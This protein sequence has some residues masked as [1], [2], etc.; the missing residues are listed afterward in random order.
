MSTKN[1]TN[2]RCLCVYYGWKRHLHIAKVPVQ[3]VGILISWP[4]YQ[5]HTSTPHLSFLLLSVLPLLNLPPIQSYPT[6]PLNTPPTLYKRCFHNLLEEKRGLSLNFQSNFRSQ[7]RETTHQAETATVFLRCW[8]FCTLFKPKCL[9]YGNF[10][11]LLG[12]QWI[13]S[14]FILSSLLIDL[15]NE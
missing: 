5:R 4:D 13:F 3:S 6:V 15:F 10:E 1:D 9:C 8:F 14:F 2:Y 12:S 11:I 7:L